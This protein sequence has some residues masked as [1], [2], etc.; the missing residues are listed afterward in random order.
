MTYTCM[1]KC[2]LGEGVTFTTFQCVHD[3]VGI[4]IFPVF[5]LLAIDHLFRT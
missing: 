3:L 2:L 1:L 5:Y 4:C